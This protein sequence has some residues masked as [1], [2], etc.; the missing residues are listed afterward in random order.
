MQASGR[1]APL[2]SEG[3]PAWGVLRF[4]AS[5]PTRSGAGGMNQERKAPLR[6]CA[7]P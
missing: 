5:S 2:W 1:A 7:A 3:G 6:G 4:D